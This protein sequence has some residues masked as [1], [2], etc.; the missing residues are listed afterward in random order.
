MTRLSS[1]T[2]EATWVEL[3]QVAPSRALFFVAQAGTFGEP[4]YYPV[5]PQSSRADGFDDRRVY[6]W[7]LLTLPFS[8]LVHRTGEPGRPG[9]S[10]LGLPSTCLDSAT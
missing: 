10:S 7:V 4:H 3:C 5:Q 6:L 8:L 1:L 9:A 2:T